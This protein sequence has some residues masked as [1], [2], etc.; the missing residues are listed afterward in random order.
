MFVEGVYVELYSCG[1]IPSMSVYSAY[2]GRIM[3]CTEGGV[4]RMCNDFVYLMGN[5]SGF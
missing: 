1:G 5:G 4:D 3:G 2:T